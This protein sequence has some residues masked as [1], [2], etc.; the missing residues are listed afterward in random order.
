MPPFSLSTVTAGIIAPLVGFAG[1]V[2]LVIA[3]AQ[4]VGATPGQTISWLAAISLAKAIGGM[5]LTWRYKIPIIMAWSTPG[6]ALIAATGGT[7]AF[8]AAEGAF[9]LAAILIILTGL[10]RPIGDLVAR[11][12]AGIASAMLAGV[13]FRFVADV[14]VMAPTTPLLVLP[15]VAIFLVARLIHGASAM[16]VVVA[17]GVALTYGLGLAGPL[18]T[19]LGLARLEWTTPTFDAATL[20]GLGLPLYLVTMAAQNLPGLAVLRANGYKPEVGP[21]LTTTGIVSLISA[22]F[23]A[24]TSNLA[25]ITAAICAGPDAHPDPARRWPSGIVYGLAFIL[26]AAFAGPFVALFAAMPKA[27]IATIA[28]LALTGALMG[29]LTI[30]MAEERARF[31]AILTFATA[32]SGVS[33]FGVGAAF[34]GLA[35]GLVALGIERLHA[36]T[37]AL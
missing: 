3:A 29:A 37:K 24:H 25:A 6:A 17:A 10:V 33:A 20:I 1:T 11:I 30:A 28:G 4:A 18:P 8:P 19:D 34:W 5:A 15:L 14:A 16:L 9:V 36:I 27:L 12:P 21:I 35:I 23:G 7:I 13:L 26:L 32:A 31:P 2:A 22:P